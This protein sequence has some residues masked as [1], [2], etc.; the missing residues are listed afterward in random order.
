MALAE[1]YQCVNLIKQYINEVKITPENVLQILP[2]ALK[3]HQ[4][5]LRK[6]YDVINC[7]VPTSKLKEVLPESKEISTTIK[8]LLNKCR[9]LE[10]AWLRCKMR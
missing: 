7:S 3:Y 8:M 9:Y 5:A 2:Y 4:A 10:L 1:E 6:M